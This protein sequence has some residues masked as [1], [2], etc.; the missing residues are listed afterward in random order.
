M[1]IYGL[2]VYDSDLFSCWNPL[3]RATV[4]LFTIL[5]IQSFLIAS[6]RWLTPVILATSYSKGRDQED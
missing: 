4:F 2:S 3:K 5:I 6:L 1:H